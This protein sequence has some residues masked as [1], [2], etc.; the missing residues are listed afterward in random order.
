MKFL[1][2]G[3]LLNSFDGRVVRVSAYG[4]LDYGSIPSRVRPMTLKL[5]SKAS[6]FDA[7]H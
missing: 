2:R 7:H 4:V 5:V 3:I 6:P 1:K